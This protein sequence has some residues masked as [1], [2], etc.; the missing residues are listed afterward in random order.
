MALAVHGYGA[1]GQS[2]TVG[3]VAVAFRR[4]PWRGHLRVRRQRV[5]KCDAGIGNRFAAGFVIVNVSEWCAFSAIVE[6]LKDLS[7]HGG[8][9]TLMLAV[10][11]PPVPP[12]VEVTLPAIRN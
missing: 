8:A 1:A 3:A 4:K 6:G 10:A 9:A 12:S 5:R 2:D 7:N 11:V